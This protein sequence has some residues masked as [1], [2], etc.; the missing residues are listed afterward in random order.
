MSVKKPENFDSVLANILKQI[1]VNK[2]SVKTDSTT[3]LKSLVADLKKMENVRGGFTHEWVSMD[4]RG[5]I[6]IPENLRNS[7]GAQNGTR[8][9][10][11]LYPDPSKPRGILLLKEE[12]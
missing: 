8:L 12:W 6:V 5:R 11:H 7:I 4:K 2:I 10:A 3:I 1:G 9:D